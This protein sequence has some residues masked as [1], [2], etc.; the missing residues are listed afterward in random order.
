MELVF[1]AELWLYPG[2]AGWHFVTLPRAIGQQ[3]K[4]YQGQDHGLRRGFGA[5]KVIARI[6]NTAWSTSLFPD[7]KSESYLLP[8]KAEVRAREK[9]GNS[10]MVKVALTLDL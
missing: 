6:G 4:F 3:V 8:V 9:I 5:V 1:E 2:K 7:A 10:T